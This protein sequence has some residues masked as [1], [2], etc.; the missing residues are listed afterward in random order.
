MVE[1]LLGPEAKPRLVMYA[2]I[3]TSLLLPL[4]GTA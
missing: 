3:N 1:R 2:V 4:T